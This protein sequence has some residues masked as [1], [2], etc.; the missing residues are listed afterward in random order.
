MV[1]RV[2]ATS[3][4]Y[5][6]V[7]FAAVCRT[8][9]D[10]AAGFGWVSQALS[11]GG[12]YCCTTGEAVKP[13]VSMELFYGPGMA[14]RDDAVFSEAKR[15]SRGDKELKEEVEENT[16]SRGSPSPSNLNNVFP[17][18]ELST[19]RNDQWKLFTEALPIVFGDEAGQSSIAISS[20]GG[21]GDA[22][23]QGLA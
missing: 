13:Q 18:R 15:R 7:V 3:Q 9:R 22:T 19:A 4:G 8:R 10:G 20:A 11:P 17:P 23:V 5:V 12:L 16:S 14:T 21:G 6:C 2:Y 1:I